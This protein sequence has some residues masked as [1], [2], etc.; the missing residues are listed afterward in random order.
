MGPGREDR[1]RTWYVTLGPDHVSLVDITEKNQSS[2][3][4]L[5]IDSYVGQIACPVW[6]F[7]DLSAKRLDCHRSMSSEWNSTTHVI[8]MYITL[9]H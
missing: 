7:E 6:G 4:Q 3:I 8:R 2:K 9:V 5:E 1:R